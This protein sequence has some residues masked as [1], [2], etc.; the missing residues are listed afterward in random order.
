MNTEF[1]PALILTLFAGF[2]QGTFGL[3]MRRFAPLA[4][5]ALWLIFSIVGMI[6]LPILCASLAVPD[7]GAAIAAA[8]CDALARAALCAFIWGA[9][10]V[11]FGLAL[12]YLGV[13]L[14]YGIAVGLSAAVGSLIPLFQLPDPWSRAA[15]PWILLGNA[16]MVAGVAVVTAAGIA[17]DREMA[18]TGREVAGIQ[19]GRL[20]WIGLLFCL[21][22]A[23]GAAMLNVAFTSAQPIAEAAVKQG[24]LPR[25]ASL[26]CW[27]AVFA[28]GVV[29][30]AG[31]ALWLLVKN[32][33]FRTFAAPGAIKGYAWAMLTAVFWFAALA[34]YGQGAALMGD[35][36]PVVAWTMFLAISLVVSGAWGIG[37]GEWRGMPKAL[38][39]LLIGDAVLLVSWGVLGY[40]NSL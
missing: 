4:W 1:L 8:P 11:T 13:S 33:S 31:Y 27:V 34:L 39:I 7:L 10:S 25:N 9:S 18:H 23:F 29:P 5:E 20:F 32:R 19:R 17:R 12:N 24:A 28:S 26:A 2:F 16:V 6:V 30:N 14:G 36:G 22:S 3:G 15:T 35:L 37:T 40:A 38:R 21:F